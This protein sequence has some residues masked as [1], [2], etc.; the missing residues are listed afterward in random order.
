M[1]YFPNFNPK[2]ISSKAVQTAQDLI[3]FYDL[4]GMPGKPVDLTKLLD[5]FELR[6][7][8]LPKTTWGFT[9]DVGYK[10][11]I[12]INQALSPELKRY[13]AMHE[14]G[15]VG[16]WHPNQLHS[17]VVGKAEYDHLENEAT[18]VAAYLLVPAEAV[19][20]PFTLVRLGELAECYSVPSELIL[21]RR[22]L[23]LSTGV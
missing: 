12:V 9:L 17:C 5:K 18:M 6:E 1:T 23:Y 21:M 19:A 20:E 4:H 14:V 11:V 16:L 22:G 8:E 2:Q 7:M 13:V 15:H 10:I 3:K